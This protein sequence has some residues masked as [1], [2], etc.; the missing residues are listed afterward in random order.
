[1][2]LEQP[3][4]V[5]GDGVKNRSSAKQLA[6]IRR[7][8]ADAVRDFAPVWPGVDQVEVVSSGSYGGRAVVTV[9]IHSRK[10]IISDGNHAQLV[11]NI[12]RLLQVVATD[13]NTQWPTIPGIGPLSAAVSQGCALWVRPDGAEFC[14]VGHLFVRTQ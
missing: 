5:A 13:G 8:A 7:S 10:Y 9:R 14:E 12:V 2:A 6:R 11:V 1:M 4:F 3:S